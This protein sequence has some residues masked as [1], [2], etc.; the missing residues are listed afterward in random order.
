LYDNIKIK[1]STSKTLFLDVT[2]I[3]FQLLTLARSLYHS[4]IFTLKDDNQ[5][6]FHTTWLPSETQI[7]VSTIPFLTFFI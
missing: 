5:L 7:K 4:P 6:D 1:S 3:A 2:H